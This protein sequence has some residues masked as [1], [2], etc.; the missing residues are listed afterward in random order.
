MGIPFTAVEKLS[1]SNE[2]L[3]CIKKKLSGTVMT[4]KKKKKKKKKKQK[5]KKNGKEKNFMK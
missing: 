5:Q 1:S 2:K 3:S 4:K